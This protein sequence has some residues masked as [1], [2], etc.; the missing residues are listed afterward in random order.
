MDTSNCQSDNRA[1]GIFG[2]PGKPTK[3]TAE[4]LDEIAEEYGVFIGVIVQPTHRYDLN[5]CDVLYHSVVKRRLRI[6]F[7]FVKIIFAETMPL[8]LVK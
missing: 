1:D 2:Y 5:A 8:L 3:A 4:I 7:R 6:L